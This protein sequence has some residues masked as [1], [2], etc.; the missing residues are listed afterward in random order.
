MSYVAERRHFPQIGAAAKTER[1]EYPVADIGNLI[2]ELGA[3]HVPAEVL[4]KGAR[5]TAGRLRHEADALFFP[6]GLTP[7]EITTKQIYVSIIAFVLSQLAVPWSAL[8]L[9]PALPDALYKG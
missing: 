4:E 6:S 7:L 5:L 8:G 3:R 2:D 9:A 1:D